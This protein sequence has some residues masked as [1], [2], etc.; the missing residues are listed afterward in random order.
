MKRSLLIV[1]LVVLSAAGFVTPST[2]FAQFGPPASG[3]TVT[4]TG[5]ASGE[6]ETAQF[7]LFLMEPDAYMG[8]PPM[9]V[10][11]ATPGATARGSAAPIDDAV[12]AA[13]GVDGVEVA[14][15]VVAD[16][17]SGPTPVAMLTV[18]M[19]GPTQDN[20]AA[21]ITTASQ[22]AIG[23]DLML[24]YVGARFSTSGCAALVQE[25]NSAALEDARQ[26]AGDQAELLNVGVGEIVGTSSFGAG[27]AVYGMPGAQNGCEATPP[28][29]S[30]GFSWMERAFPRFDP[31]LDVV[32]VQVVRQLTVTFA[33][34]VVDGTPAG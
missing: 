7:Q 16:P 6:A 12:T 18:A 25:A 15:P 9:P 21:M 8:P 23:N 19:T 24:G 27:Y 17:F 34:A 4:G 14:V 26:Q 10:A 22:A 20:V 3:I 5:I 11:E 33:I 28:V 1:V 30:G 13:E 2:G 32:E 29:S 31:S